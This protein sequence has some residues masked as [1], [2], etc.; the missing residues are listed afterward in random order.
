[1]VLDGRKSWCSG[2][3]VVTHA[4]VTAAEPD[5][6]GGLYAVALKQPGV[7]LSDGEWHAVGM[8]PSASVSV[9]FDSA[10]AVRVATGGQYTARP[11]F[12][13]GGAGVAACWF[14]AAAALGQAVLGAAEEH[15]DP[16]RHAHLGHIVVALGAA[17]AS[18][19]EAAAAIDR[20]P[21]VQVRWIALR[22]RLCVEHAAT[23]V[24]QHTGRALGAGPLCQNARL[25]RLMADLP[26]FMRQSHGEHCT[27][28]IPR[29]P[30]RQCARAGG[31]A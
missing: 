23:I 11:G 22:A 19:R 1:V 5:G 12:W 14:G 24:L 16:H 29:A 3:A 26:V 20:M 15:P 28:R 2:A 4:L 27:G 25:A 7:S 6:T 9:H 17:A 31:S 30:R 21:N 8:H 13:H 10:S 18:L